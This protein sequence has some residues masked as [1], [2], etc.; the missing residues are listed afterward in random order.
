V[1]RLNRPE[2]KTLYDGT[3]EFI[4]QRSDAVQ[5]R[6]KKGTRSF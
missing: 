2:G 5:E 6:K 1:E 3:N 4:K